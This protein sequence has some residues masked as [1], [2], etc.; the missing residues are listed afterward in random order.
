MH[1][2]DSILEESAKH[3]KHLCPRQVL[4]ARMGL[5][6]APLFGLELPR[7]DKRLLAIAEMDGC[8]VDGLS[9]AT[10]CRVGNRTLRI[11]DFG[12]VAVTFVDLYTETSIRIN[13]SHQSRT[14]AVQY[15][16]EA[17]NRWEAML[18]G[19]QIMPVTELFQVQPV[20]LN[21]SVSEM[22]SRASKNAVCEAC[23]EEIMNGREVTNQGIILCRP[24]AG[25]SYYHFSTP[26]R[27][28][29]GGTA[30]MK[31]ESVQKRC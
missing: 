3:H 5:Y 30:L 4:G 1:T 28:S 25:D 15:A 9:A 20:Q 13:P 7:K 21:V 31:A 14:L 12:K 6:A 2:L 16:T 29:L 11:L 18:V 26:S 19:Y 27:L 10:G 8:M 17:R 23:G 24:C 22:I